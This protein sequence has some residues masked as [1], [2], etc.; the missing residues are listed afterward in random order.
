MVVDH[1][2]QCKMVGVPGSGLGKFFLSY[3]TV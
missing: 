2:K 1:F 3:G